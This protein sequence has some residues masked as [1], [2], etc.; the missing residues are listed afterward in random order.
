MTTTQ[1]SQTKTAWQCLLAVVFG[2]IFCTAGV[3]RSSPAG[4]V[5]LREHSVM[6]LLKQG[7]FLVLIGTAFNTQH[8]PAGRNIRLLDATAACW[9]GVISFAVD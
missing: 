5:N 9:D 2:F 6:P 3:H 1:T 8:P 4:V 7:F